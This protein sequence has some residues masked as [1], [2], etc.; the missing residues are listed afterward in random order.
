[1]M[2]WLITHLTKRERAMYRIAMRNAK[3]A[4]AVDG[5]VFTALV[6]EI[7]EEDALKPTEAQE[8]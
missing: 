5:Q 8:R 7:E 3:D 6:L 1:M 4:E 2:D